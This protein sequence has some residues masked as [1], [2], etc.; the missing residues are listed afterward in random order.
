LKLALCNLSSKFNKQLFSS[1][2]IDEIQFFTLK[3]IQETITCAFQQKRPYVGQMSP[4]WLMFKTGESVRLIFQQYSH[5]FSH[6]LR[7]LSKAPT[8]AWGFDC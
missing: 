5:K 6:F 1:T 4:T 3:M 2:T 8:R 7:D